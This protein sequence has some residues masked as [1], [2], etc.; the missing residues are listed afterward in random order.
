M[1]LH[2]GFILIVLLAE[3]SQSSEV[4]VVRKLAELDSKIAQLDAKIVQLERERTQDKAI[5]QAL[6]KSNK[7]D[8]QQTK[9]IKTKKGHADMFPVTLKQSFRKRD[10]FFDGTA[11]TACQQAATSENVRTNQTVV[12]EHVITNVGSWYNPNNGEFT[13]PINGV[14]AFHVTL[15]T[16]S[17][18]A[19]NFEIVIDGRRIDGMGT[20]ASGMHE[21]RSTSELWLLQLNKGSKVWIRSASAG[22]RIHGNCHAMLS[23][24]YIR[25]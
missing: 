17:N 1:R 9:T 24:F 8:H 11:F 13:A 4:D 25:T 21:Y 19:A 5:I 12:F 14:F 15:M 23:G 6:Q 10:N 20:D 2:I 7:H 18:A 16:E 3:S 22:Y